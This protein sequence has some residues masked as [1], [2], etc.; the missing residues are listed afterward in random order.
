MAVACLCDLECRAGGPGLSTLVS[1]WSD[2]EPDFV[3]A[4][5]LRS[6]IL[7][8][9]PA[10]HPSYLLVLSIK[11]VDQEQTVSF[12][13]CGHF[14]QTSPAKDLSSVSILVPRELVV[15]GR[16]DLTLAHHDGVKV[17]KAYGGDDQRVLSVAVSRLTLYGTD[18]VVA[19]YATSPSDRLA[20]KSLFDGFHSLGNNCEFGFC[21][22]RF[23]SE[24]LHFLKF[25]GISLPRLTLGLA[26]GFQD[27]GTRECISYWLDGAQDGPEEAL[28]YMIRHSLYGLNS[29]S[30]RRRGSMSG[31]A[32]ITQTQQ[33]LEFLQRKFVEDLEDA[34]R[35]YV[36]KREAPLSLQ[37]VMPVW[38]T[39]RNYG[40]NTLLYV[41]KATGERT[42]GTVE[43][44]APGLLCGY[45]DTF[46]PPHDINDI[47]EHC[48]ISICRKAHHLWRQERDGAA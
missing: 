1:G 35:I 48:W 17:S 9:V 34:D 38:T 19:G 24:Q 13:A 32:F 10:E 8:D 22:R 4:L 3:W 31:E 15:D 20:L 25:A 45:I 28:E 47:S 21:Q 23:G 40:D 18:Q 7:V 26:S 37:E 33:R 29:H 42:P 6:R 16:I 2:P 11:A 44:K 14:I 46:V 27:L 36:L 30:F 5:G 43:R 41:V 39:L 12:W